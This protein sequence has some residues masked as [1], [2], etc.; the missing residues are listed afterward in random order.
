M[1]KLEWMKLRIYGN[2]Q[3]LITSEGPFLGFSILSADRILE[4][5]MRGVVAWLEI[6]GDEHA[7]Y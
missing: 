5:V 2:C 4:A 7:T 6:A 3:L 1:W